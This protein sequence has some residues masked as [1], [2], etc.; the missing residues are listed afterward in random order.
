MEYL[1][2][3][4]LL[5]RAKDIVA[6]VVVLTTAA[7]IGLLPIDESKHWMKLFTHALEELQLRF[8]AYPAGLPDGFMADAQIPL[9]RSALAQAAGRAVEVRGAVPLPYLVKYGSAQHMGSAYETGEIRISPATF[10]K[11]PSLNSA[12]RDDELEISIQRLDRKFTARASSNYHVYCLSAILAPR[13]FFDFKKD[14][15]LLILKPELFLER[16]AAKVAEQIPDWQRFG[17]S[18]QYVDPLRSGMPHLGPYLGKHF[19]YAY[20]KEY[21]ALWIPPDPAV[22]LHNHITVYLG[23]LQDCCELILL[24]SDSH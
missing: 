13:L 20:Q 14:A 1:N 24:S 18:V 6:N 15:C 23:S 3:Q 7:K 19:R 22:A 10:F 2:H 17:S 9:P 16:L 4:E 8:G 12:I 5:Q 21:R 11:D